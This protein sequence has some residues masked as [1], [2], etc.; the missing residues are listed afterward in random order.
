[1]KQIVFTAAILLVGI[2][3]AIAKDH[4]AEQQLLDTAQ[5]P[6]DLF[7][8]KAD[9]FDLEID[10]SAQWNVPTRG[11]FSLNWKSKDQ[12][13][14]KVEIGGFEQITIQN[15]EMQYILRNLGFT[16]ISIRELFNLLH[17]MN[18][19]PHFVA[20]KLKN[21]AENDVSM[22]CVQAEREDYRNDSHEFCLDAASHELLSDD[23]QIA[24]DERAREQFSDYS[25][26]D[27]IR[28]PTKLRLFENGGSEI[29]AALISLQMT[30]L[31]DGSVDD[32][33]L[34]SRGGHVIDDP[35]MAALK[36]WKFKP[37]MCGADPVVADIQVTVSFRSN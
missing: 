35:T 28:Y 21:R 8:G 11:H 12:W 7:Q 3:P 2:C 24:P 30:V 23:W 31:T 10:F 19:P 1:M 20:T 27:G 26:F 25:E 18:S 33:H 14:S 4:T 37:A 22:S 13:R 17:F 32:I 29:S 36:K 6:A 16:P 34:I 15:G 5:K 9:P